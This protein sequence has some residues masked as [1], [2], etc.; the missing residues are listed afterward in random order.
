[1][2]DMGKNELGRQSVTPCSS[3]VLPVLRCYLWC[4]VTSARLG[5]R[6][7]A[8]PGQHVLVGSFQGERV[9][10]FLEPSQ[11]GF[12]VTNTLLEAAHLGYHAGIGTAN[13][14]E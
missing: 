1:M 14:A 4:L 12:Q 3:A 9:V 11:L 10:E 5:E 2:P 7:L 8:I 6:G 13:V